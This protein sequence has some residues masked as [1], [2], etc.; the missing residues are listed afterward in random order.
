MILQLLHGPICPNKAMIKV[1]VT[2]G[3]RLP[4][5]LKIE[6]KCNT[7]YTSFITKP[8]WKK[9]L[10]IKRWNLLISKNLFYQDSNGLLGKREGLKVP[11]REDTLPT[12]HPSGPTETCTVVCNYC[13]IVW[14]KCKQVSLASKIRTSKASTCTSISNLTSSYQSIS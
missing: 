6:K 7:Q 9:N 13:I 2:L 14:L 10:Q 5:Y 11:A 3:S 12:M 8:H 1:S 4:T